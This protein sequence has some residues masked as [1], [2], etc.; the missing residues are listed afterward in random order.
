MISDINLTATCSLLS[1]SSPDGGTIAARSWGMPQDCKFG[2]V[3]VHGLGAHSGWFEAFARL[4]KVK[5]GFCLAYD[6]RGFGRRQDESFT[7]YT[8]WID[9]LN[10]VFDYGQA[11]I[12]DRPLFLVGNSMG[13]VVALA[14]VSFLSPAG[15]VLLSP[16]LDGHPS[17]FSLNYK[18]QAILKAFFFPNK[19]V[20]IP[21]GFDRACREPR[22]VDWLESDPA[23]RNRVPAYMLLE[24]LKL[25]KMVARERLNIT[26][27]VLMMTAGHEFIVNSQVNESFFAGLK[28]TRK[29]HIHFS[30]AWHDLMFDPLVDEVADAFMSWQAEI[31]L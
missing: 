8:Q 31:R 7:S 28:T 17:T 4:L 10:T 29:Q 20:S 14:A 19:E 18:L 12:G 15:L 13:A 21:Y 9:D 1:I 25:T 30:E 3:L 6:Q 26:L 11:Q 24:L 16:G 2:V 27:P 23:K 5:Q 22:V